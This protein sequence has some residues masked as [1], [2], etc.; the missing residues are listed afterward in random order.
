MNDNMLIEGGCHCGNIKFTY[1]VPSKYE[2]IPARAC[3]CS[4][5]TRHG[6]TYTSHPDAVLSIAFDLPDKINRYRFGTATADFY[7]CEI[8][9]V[10]TFAVSRIDKK[11][12]AVVNINA[13]KDFDQSALQVD[14]CDYDDETE[15]ERLSR[16]KAR[17]IGNVIFT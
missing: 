2:S 9:G 15:T 5:C 16:R 1:S 7:I 10:I 12:Y 14:S 13:F 11:D 3:G 8:C 17:W 4:F 6:G